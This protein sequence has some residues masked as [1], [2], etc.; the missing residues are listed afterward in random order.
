MDEKLKST[1]ICSG[2]LKEARDFLL[3]RGFVEI[4]PLILTRLSDPLLETK[5]AKTK[6]YDKEYFLTTS[7]IFQKQILMNYFEKIFIV[8]PNIRIEKESPHHLVEF[9]QL[10]VE[11]RNVTKEK[12]MEF[13]ED[14]VIYIIR[15]LK[16]K[17]PQLIKVPVPEKPF[18]RISVKEMK[19]KYGN[20][21]NL[22]QSIKEP[23]FL[24]DFLEEEREFYDREDP[25][26]YG[27][28]L[29]YDLI[30]PFGFGEG[31][32]GGEREYEYE[33]I[34][35]RIKRKGLPLSLFKEYLE[36]AKERKLK[37]SAGFGL[38]IERMVKY[39]LGLDHIR[40]TRIFVY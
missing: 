2:V 35:D 1:L 12:V 6:I 25:Q 37:P 24:V 34:V 17:Y 11:M 16:E 27:I 33:R 39:L 3:E 26:R 32:S 18:K 14:L 20:M 5:Y 30:Y 7:M 31:L 28:L 19:E 4:L 23:Y 15:N 22:S 40:K 8:S 29:D 13:I 10:D 21:L 38:G 9:V 36:Y